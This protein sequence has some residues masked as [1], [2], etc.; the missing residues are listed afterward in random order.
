MEAGIADRLWTCA[1]IA[2][3]LERAEADKSVAA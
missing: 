3:L 2:A 1:D